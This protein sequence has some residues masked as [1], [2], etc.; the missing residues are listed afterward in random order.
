MKLVVVGGHSRNIGKT[1]V[2]AGLVHALRGCR[3]TAVK[4]TQ[5]GHGICSRTSE[6]CSCTPEE[7]DCP[8]D[9]REERDATGRG[10]TC[11]F[12]AAGAQRAW[13][14]RARVGHLALAMP[15]LRQAIARD[16]HVIIESNSVLAF[17]EPNLYLP[18]LDPAVADFKESANQFINRADAYVAVGEQEIP[19]KLADRPVFRVPRGIYL[20]PE[21][22]SFVE[23][24]LC[25]AP[26]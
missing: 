2:V 25:L 8:F 23:G 22:V 12:L 26:P 16:E 18:V 20:T 4:I 19:W 17:L 24:R 21:V 14:V 6:P 1:S 9:I 5:F 15:S 13:W 7:P 10:D 11:R 3:W